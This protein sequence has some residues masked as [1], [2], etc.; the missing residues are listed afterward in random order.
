MSMVLYSVKLRVF[1]VSK[2]PQKNHAELCVN[3]D[4]P[5]FCMENS[6][7]TNSKNANAPVDDIDRLLTRDEVAAYLNIGTTFIEKL[8]RSGKLPSFKI[9]A[10]CVRYKKSDC[11]I[12][13][14]RSLIARHVGKERK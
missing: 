7:N 4:T 12:L 14:D 3:F 10:K 11:D 6:N 13:L 5:Q 2:I 1:V 9:S 8:R